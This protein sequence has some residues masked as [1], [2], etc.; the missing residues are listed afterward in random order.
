MAAT[1]RATPLRCHR[2]LGRR[3]VQGTEAGSFFDLD[4]AAGE[5]ETID[6]PGY[7]DE[8]ETIGG[9]RAGGPNG[10]TER[11]WNFP[12]PDS[13]LPPHKPFQN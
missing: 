9:A 13:K 11:C 5:P 4:N 7:G 6:P 10:A 8:D 3:R 2:L 1:W 12:W